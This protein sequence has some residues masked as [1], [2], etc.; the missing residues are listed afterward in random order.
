LENILIDSRNDGILVKLTD[1][2]FSTFK[3]STGKLNKGVGSRYY[4][5]PEILKKHAYD[6]KIDVWSATVVVYILLIGDMPYP[7]KNVKEVAQM[8]QR[9]DLEK[10]LS[11]LKFLSR[12]AQDFLKAGMTQKPEMRMS[13]DEMLNH[14]FLQSAVLPKVKV[15]KPHSLQEA[16]FLIR[17]GH[18]VPQ[19]FQESLIKTLFRCESDSEEG[20]GQ[21]G[22][23]SY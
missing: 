20:V 12:E 8:I 14:P 16:L 6:E 19:E 21:P 1:F 11:K 3:P 4:I 22:E 18:K 17:S 23:N 2:G 7:G 9:K 5:A 15:Q 10:D 13:I